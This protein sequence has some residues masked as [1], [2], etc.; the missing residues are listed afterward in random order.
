M[1]VDYVSA[2]KSKHSFL[3]LA[4]DFNLPQIDWCFSTSNTA[5]PILELLFDMAFNDPLIHTVTERT[6]PHASGGAVLD[7]NFISEGISR[8]NYK[9]KVDARISAHFIA[10]V[11]D[12]VPFLA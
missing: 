6:R 10:L 2:V 12:V 1:L 4:G 5:C 7:L 3:I 11:Q 8:S 9:C